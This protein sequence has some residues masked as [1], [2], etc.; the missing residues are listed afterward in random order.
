MSNYSY[1]LV[2]YNIS[3]YYKYDFKMDTSNMGLNRVKKMNKTEGKLRF[4]NSFSDD[5]EDIKIYF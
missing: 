3:S 2:E 5:Q 1:F 4:I